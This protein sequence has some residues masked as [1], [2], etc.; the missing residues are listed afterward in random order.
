MMDKSKIA[1]VTTVVSFELY[2]RTA[3]LFPKGIDKIVID[4]TTGLYG[5][6][7]IKLIF[8]KKIFQKY[9]WIILADE[10]VFFYDSNLVFRLIE[11]M[12]EQEYDICGVRDGGVIKHRFDNPLAVNTFFC[13][14]NY[15]EIVKQ[16]NFDK[17]MKCQ[18]F[19][20]ELYLKEDFS[21][22]LYAYNIKSLKEPYYCFFFWA[23]LNEYKFLY[24]DTVNP[25]NN[26][27]IGN[28]I[29]NNENEKIGFHSWYA[30]AYNVYDDQTM[31]INAFLEDFGL[32]NEEIKPQKFYIIRSPF[33]NWKKRS[34]KFIK[35]IF[36]LK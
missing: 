9:D 20:P 22:L 12:Q 13:V 28:V 29:L 23:A 4:G 1:I 8:E 19:F 32:V 24:L 5:I 31:R 30:R 10:D 17:V 25:V 16:F 6:Q 11:Q 35:K 2:R 34:K 3:T 15:K 21:N 7:S 36:K 18:R 27:V 14:V 33:Y 26:D